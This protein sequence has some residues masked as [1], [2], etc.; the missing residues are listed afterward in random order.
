MISKTPPDKAQT[1]LTEK[2]IT[3]EN[4]LNPKA[5]LLAQDL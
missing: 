5:I 3:D 4:D 2:E 1:Q